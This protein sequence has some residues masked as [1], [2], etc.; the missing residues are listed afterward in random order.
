MKKIVLIIMFL[1][2][3]SSFSFSADDQE[4]SKKGILRELGVYGGYAK[5]H[6]DRQ[7]PYHVAQM[8]LRFGF[9][10]NPLLAKIHL[11]PPIGEFDFVIEPFI[12]PII[13]PRSNVEL[14]AALMFKYMLPLSKRFSIY[15]EFGAAPSYY[16]LHTQEQSTQFN[17]I[18]Q[19]G[20]GFYVFLKDG[21][22][23]NAGY[24]RRHMSNASIK[25]PNSGINTDS[26]LLGLSYFK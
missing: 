22:A 1:F 11:K 21:L 17:F 3:F 8:G 10:M 24:R 26:Y 14:G 9:D 13:D 5:G 25:R 19:A 2:I 12:N 20:G 15:A 4:E 16:T 6:L 23:L 7:G 18:D